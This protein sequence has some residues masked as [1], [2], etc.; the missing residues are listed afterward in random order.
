MCACVRA[1][2]YDAYER[3]TRR[4]GSQQPWLGGISRICLAC[5]FQKIIVTLFLSKR[6]MFFCVS[7]D[8]SGFCIVRVVF[9]CQKITVTYLENVFVFQWIAVTLCLYNV[10]CLCVTDA[11]SLERVVFVCSRGSQ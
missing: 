1:C 2:D 5:V 11:L 9:V 7:E 6:N 4:G 3:E 10:L 8:N